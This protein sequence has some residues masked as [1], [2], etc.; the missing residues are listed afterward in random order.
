MKS[1]ET[2]EILREIA[3]L[4]ELSGENPFKSRAYENG[5]RTLESQPEEVDFLVKSGKLK[6]LPGF[7]PALIEKVTTLVTTGKLPYLNELKKTV[8]AGL[9]EMI[10]IPGMGP[11]KVKALYDRLKIDSIPKLQ[12]ACEEHRIAKLEGF[13]EKTEKKILDGIAHL[14]KYAERHL[15]DEAYE[16]AAGLVQK[17]KKHP[18]VDRCETAG[19][20]RRVKETIGDVDIL[21]SSQ[22]PE[23]VIDFFTK[24]E[25]VES[26]IAHG[27][28]KGA[29]SLKDSGLQV[30]LRVVSEKEF[31][32][33][34]Q[35]FT[36]GK[37]HNTLLRSRSKEMGLKLNEYGLFNEKGKSLSCKNEEEI[38][39]ALKLDY[40]PPE[41][42]EANGEIEAAEKHKIPD[43]VKEKD[44]CGVFHVHSTW[45]DGTAPLEKMISEAERLGFD[46][47]GIS[48]HS[49]SASYANG[50]KP[51]RVLKQQKEIEKLRKKFKI[52]IFWGIESD[53]LPNGNLDYPEKI[54]ERFDFIIA[55][56]HSSFTMPEKEM[57]ARIIKALRNKHTT[58]LGHA[59][60][61]LLLSREPYAVDMKKV[62]DAAA[63]EGKAI[64]INASPHR[65]DL[66]WR[67]CSYAKEMKVKLSINPDAHSI[68]GL[69]DYRYGVGIARKGWLTK[70]DVLT[71]YP[72]FKME[73]HLS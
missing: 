52:R 40:I 63:A 73:K 57:T 17:L 43:L 27:D 21:V 4:L 39:K 48:D 35:Y 38:Y 36:G 20:L 62:I 47:V 12:K 70:E 3:L 60:G 5:A 30:D 69:S 34:L 55:S 10:R 29:V 65:F 32:F 19:S 23:A 16:A 37:E 50:M 49:Q 1:S 7:G 11:K 41:L 66:D 15:Y 9:L 67:L 61:R 42:R 24:L 26:V 18:Q 44:L 28:T 72:L 8:P 58:I 56:V 51:D 6:D 14:Q 33:A 53:I 54:L 2:V 31:P 59:T 13:G 25:E 22:K 45:S 68:E 71:A 64:E 46:Y